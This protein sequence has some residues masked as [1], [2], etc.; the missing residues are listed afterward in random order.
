MSDLFDAALAA[1]RR[2]TA[3]IVERLRGTGTI[4]RAD[5]NAALTEGFGGSDADGRWSQ[6]DSFEFLEHALALYLQERPYPLRSL[7]DAAAACDLLDRLPTQTVRSEDQVEWQ[8]FSTPV[9]LAAVATVLADIR[10]D[11]IVLE[12]SAGNGLL[13]AQCPARAGLQLNE[14]EPVRRTRLKHAFPDA[15]VTALGGLAADIQPL[16]NWKINQPISLEQGVLFV[17]YPTL[18]SARGDHSRLRQIIDWAGD[19]FEGV[20]GFDEAHEMGGVAGGEGALGKKEGSQQG[21]CGVLLQNFLPGARVLYASATGASDVNN[22]AY[23][24]R[25][26]LWGPETA[27]ANREQFIAEIRKG[28]IAAMEL[29]ARDLKALGLYTARALSFAGV[30]YEVP[31]PWLREKGGLMSTTLGTS[32]GSSMSSINSPSCMLDVPSGRA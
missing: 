22:L 27:F 6:R 31:R 1:E 4:T 21:I 32:C 26:G 7:A 25:L 9:D 12:P 23:A 2:A 10:G 17:T 18:R 24:V 30:E 13:I 3:L 14:Y 8:Q 20:I 28:G 29:V 11:D 16:A 5:L 15:V 19:D